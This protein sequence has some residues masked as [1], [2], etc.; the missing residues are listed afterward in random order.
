[1]GVVLPEDDFLLKLRQICDDEKILLIFDEVIT[2]FH[3]ALAGL[4][5]FLV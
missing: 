1:M 3:L 5:N 2:G 4:R